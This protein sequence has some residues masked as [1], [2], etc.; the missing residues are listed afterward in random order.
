MT[1]LSKDEQFWGRKGKKN[2]MHFEANCVICI[3]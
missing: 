2:G 1:F 3:Q